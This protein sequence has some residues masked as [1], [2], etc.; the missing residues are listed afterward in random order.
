M[1]TQRH[2]DEPDHHLM[3]SVAQLVSERLTV[4]QEVAGSNPVGH[5][6]RQNELFI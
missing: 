5:P 4:N 2:T 1:R 3:V 6:T